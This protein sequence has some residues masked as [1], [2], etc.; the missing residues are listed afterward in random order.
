M[1]SD[2]RDF[3]IAV[4]GGGPAGLT[5][6]LY[7]G[8]NMDS[9]VLFESK[10]PGGQLLNTELIEDYPGFNSIL[11]VELAEAMAGQA[12]RFGTE[13]VSAD[14]SRV[15][16]LPDGTKVLETGAGEYRAPAV[17]ITAGG[18]PRKLDIPGESEFAGRGVSYCAV[19]DGAFFK[20]VHLA[21]VG[22]GDAA[23]EEAIFLTRHASHV[24][25]IHR[26]QEFRA[27]PILM[28]EARK[29][30]QIEFLL[31]TVVEAIE[32]DDKVRRLSLR[33]QV[34]GARST[35]DVE[36]VFIFVGFIPNTG[37][38]DRHVDHDKAGYYIT[39]P[40]TMMTS[41][42]GIFAAGDV[43]SQLTRQITT[44]VGDATTATIAASKW[45]EDWKRDN[46]ETQAAA[47]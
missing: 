29:N 33:N 17:I 28:D 20:D 12:A 14:V 46:V 43:R 34:S 6:A 30:P 24:T 22:G 18:N 40:M 4:I 15:R 25:L 41:V 21:V 36:G 16:V 3:D 2:N 11:G 8:R 27:Q 13:I 38:V 19:C 42:P 32:G 44:A 26:R 45:V 37:L 5:A 39:D 31:D 10:G 7:A 9:A 47:V 23:V 35:L 1:T